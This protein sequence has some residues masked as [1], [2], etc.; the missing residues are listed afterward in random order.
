MDIRP[1]LLD[2][3]IKDYK[4]PEDLTGE[5]GLLKQFTKALPERAAAAEL[6]HEFGYDKHSKADKPTQNRR[7]GVSAKTVASKHGELQLGV[8]RD[9]N[10]EFEPQIVKKNQR[11]FDGFDGLILSLYSRG[12]STSKIGAHIEE[13]YRVEA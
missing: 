10:A 5:N 7:N 13:I 4:N 8:P 12:L 3:L 11:R 2:E 1:E 6:T 9:R